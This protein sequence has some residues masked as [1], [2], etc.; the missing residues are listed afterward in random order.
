MFAVADILWTK[1]L[2]PQFEVCLCLFCSRSRSEQSPVNRVQYPCSTCERGRWVW[3][4]T[5]TACQACTNRS[6]RKQWQPDEPCWLRAPSCKYQVQCP[7][8]LLRAYSTSDIAN[9]PWQSDLQHVTREGEWTW[10]NSF[11]TFIRSACVAPL[12]SLCWYLCL[13][14]M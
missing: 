8:F 6:L 13:L 10:K 9:L 1:G 14:R 12:W 5:G 7:F 2:S 11:L 3:R 4:P